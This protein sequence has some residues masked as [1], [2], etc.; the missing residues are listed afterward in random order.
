MLRLLTPLFLFVGLAAE[1]ADGAG[2]SSLRSRT[3][4]LFA[5]VASPGSPGCALAVIR[6]GAIAYAHGYGSASLE[7]DTPITPATVFDIG[8]ISKQFTA[9]VIQLLA[10]EGKLSL[11]DDVRR[12]IPELPD[13]GATI[14][15]RHLLHHTSGLRDIE[16][17]MALAGWDEQEVLGEE[18]ALAMIVR[19]RATNHAPGAEFVYCN[20]GYLLLSRIVKRATGSSLRAVAHERLFG[21]LGMRS[22][23]FR[24]DH[25]QVIPRQ[26]QAYDPQ[27]NGAFRIG[28]TNVEWVGDGGVHSTVED[29]ARWQRNFEV[30]TV[31]GPGFVEAML[32]PGV[33]TGGHVLDYGSGLVLG[34]REGLR[35]VH[36]AGTSAAFRAYLLGIPD[37][38]LSVACLCN[39]GGL[40]PKPLADRVAEIWLG[41]TPPQAAMATAAPPPA[42]VPAVA[43]RAGRYRNPESG[44]QRRILE[45]D[46][47]LFVPLG[48][49]EWEL[50]PLGGQEYVLAGGFG[51]V[52]IAFDPAGFTW[53]VPAIAVSA[54]FD[55]FQ[56]ARPTREELTALTGRY[57]S[58]EVDAV[59]TL[60]MEDTALTAR[61]ARSGPRQVL[62]PAVRDEFRSGG[63][64]LR[65]TR[66]EDGRVDGFSANQ[67]RVRNI[68]F[69]RVP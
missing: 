40:N 1:G 37:R 24:D 3:D 35:V 50:Q 56:Q 10:A 59:W 26:A 63:V 54:R 2:V 23:V 25:A 7:W 30:P 8:S 14:T 67:G 6:D 31:G 43:D 27:D 32:R 68:R 52:N 34:R 38:R 20:T 49:R 62:L 16:S 11:D 5:N 65:F 69:D 48:G 39:H 46:G 15:I 19:Q 47:R 17:L 58:E 4:A 33:L 41:A 36:H 57:R 42:A 28:A 22:T 29:L 44:D 61:G 60:A 18:Q 55:R 13:Y 53:R 45:R 51:Q 21:P 64:V 12:W 9:A 66:S